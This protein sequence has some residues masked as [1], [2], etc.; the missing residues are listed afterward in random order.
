V[1]PVEFKISIIEGQAKIIDRRKKSCIYVSLRKFKDTVRIV[2]PP[3]PS[4][5]SP[6]ACGQGRIEVRSRQI[7]ASR[8][9]KP[10]ARLITEGVTDVLSEKGA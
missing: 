4:S 6:I 9:R 1:Q 3:E 8:I 10:L 2:S 7:E 5:S